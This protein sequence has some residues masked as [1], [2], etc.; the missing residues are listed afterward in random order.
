MP[1]CDFMNNFLIWAAWLV[2][3]WALATSACGCGYGGGKDDGGGHGGC[4]W[5]KREEEEEQGYG[6]AGNQGFLN[7]GRDWM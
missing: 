1:L 2:S 3:N 6:C 5:G 4:A 7:H